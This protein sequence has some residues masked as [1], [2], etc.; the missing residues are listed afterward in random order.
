MPVEARAT[1]T[2]RVDPIK[3]K[4][5]VLFIP[6][7]MSQKRPLAL[8]I[9]S[10]KESQEPAVANGNAT[11]PTNNAANLDLMLCPHGVK[12]KYRVR[13]LIIYFLGV[14]FLRLTARPRESFLARFC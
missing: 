8:F 11:K 1:Q 12:G 9:G 3:N 2:N 4:V 13:N 5:R 10:R 7:R 14:S 6:P